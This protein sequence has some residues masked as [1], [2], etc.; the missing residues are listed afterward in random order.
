MSE[1]DLFEKRR[2]TLDFSQN[3]EQKRIWLE[4]I[5][6]FLNRIVAALRK[7]PSHV[8]TTA[9]ALLGRLTQSKGRERVNWK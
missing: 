6:R 4:E 8:S 7:V 2:R 9:L 5:L 1:I 3:R